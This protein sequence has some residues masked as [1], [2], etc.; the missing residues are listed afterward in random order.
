MKAKFVL[1]AVIFVM[2]ALFISSCSKSVST[3]KYFSSVSCT[4][5]DDTLNTYS[6]KI[7]TILNSRCATSGC[8]NA[9]SSSSGKDYSSYN[10]AVNGF[11]GSALCAINHDGG[12]NPMPQ[13]SSKLSDADI[14]DLTCWAKNNY[15]Q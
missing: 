14:H 1:P 15:P 10:A 5:T 8:H 4:E 12:C 9:S 7:H 3:D 2:I 6:G 13:G 11:S